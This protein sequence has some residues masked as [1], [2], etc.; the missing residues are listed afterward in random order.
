M[1]WMAWTQPTVIFF[2]VIAS[3]L[4]LFTVL[5]LKI[6]RKP[7]AWACFGLRRRAVTVCSSRFWKCF[8]QS[9]LAGS[10][11]SRHPALGN[12]SLPGLCRSGVPLGLDQDSAQA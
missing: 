7:R 11:R 8:H 4:V 3:L 9:C 1:D 6:S 12:G 2:G 10:G 5:A